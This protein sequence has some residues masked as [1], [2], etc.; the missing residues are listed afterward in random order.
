MFV[1]LCLYSELS[2]KFGLGLVGLVIRITYV[3]DFIYTDINIIDTLIIE[4]GHDRKHS[5]RNF[6]QP[7]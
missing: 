5:H 2:E 1:K 6:E 3:L 4:L 7:D